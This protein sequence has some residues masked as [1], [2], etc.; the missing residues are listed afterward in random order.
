MDFSPP[1]SSVH[2]ISQ[3]RNSRTGMGCHFLLQGIFLTQG[4]NPHLLHWQADSLLLSH[5]ESLSCLLPQRDHLG[6]SMRPTL[7]GV[8]RV[9]LLLASRG[10]SLQQSFPPPPTATKNLSTGA[11]SETCK[12]C[13]YFPQLK[14]YLTP[15]T[16]SSTT[17]SF[18]TSVARPVVCAYCL[19][20]FPFPFT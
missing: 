16:V 7:P 14:S 17:V 18:P 8:H 12:P 4:S 10:T 5:L 2:G 20:L 1:G 3:A 6:P 9:L 19:Q 13:C 11:F 15:S